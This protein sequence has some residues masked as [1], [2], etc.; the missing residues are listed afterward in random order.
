MSMPRIKGQG[1]S[2]AG[3]GGS[4]KR[5]RRIR[6]PRRVE[7]RFARDEY[8]VIKL[9]RTFKRLS[10]E[11]DAETEFSK[12]KLHFLRRLAETQEREQTRVAIQQGKR[13]SERRRFLGD[14]VFI[15]PLSRTGMP[16]ME[17]RFVSF[18]G[19]MSNGQ[20][21]LL[22]RRLLTQK[23]F[24][25]YFPQLGRT[26]ERTAAIHS[27]VVSDRP[28]PLGMYEI[29]VQ[30]VRFTPIDEGDV[31]LLSNVRRYDFYFSRPVH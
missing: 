1:A 21:T 11:R 13:K 15:I 23:E 25:L 9:D 7:S 8:V 28:L 18:C 2:A 4:A 22:H 20:C 24:I 6:R 3:Q 30:F 16:Q 5:A 26:N 14:V 12:E 27:R 17:K 10:D 31:R 29:L 19:G